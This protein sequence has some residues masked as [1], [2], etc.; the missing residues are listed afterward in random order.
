MHFYSQEQKQAASDVCFSVYRSSKKEKKN[1]HS[2]NCNQYSRA[3]STLDKGTSFEDLCTWRINFYSAGTTVV[4][5]N[6]FK[7]HHCP[8]DNHGG[9]HQKYTMTLLQDFPGRD[10]K[11]QQWFCLCLRACIGVF[12][13]FRVTV[14][15]CMRMYMWRPEDNRGCLDAPFFVCLFGWVDFGFGFCF[16]LLLIVSLLCV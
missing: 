12:T 16:V 11:I 8:S 13:Y 5:W 2:K 15:T 7:V 9:Q 6:F 4:P 3:Q 14:H 1:C 10:W